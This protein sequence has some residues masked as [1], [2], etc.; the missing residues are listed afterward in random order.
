VRDASAWEAHELRLK[1]GDDLRESARRGR[2]VEI[3]KGLAR[4]ERI[5]VEGDGA[6]LFREQHE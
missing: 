3:V 6:L 5:F 2:S 1:V 4:E